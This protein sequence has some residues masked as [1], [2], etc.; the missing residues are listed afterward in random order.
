MN[1]MIF[2]PSVCNVSIPFHTYIYVYKIHTYLE[3]Y[4]H[5]HNI[6]VLYIHLFV[7][8]MVLL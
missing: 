3:M 7:E 6:C 4:I 8:W 1:L 5:I 2:C